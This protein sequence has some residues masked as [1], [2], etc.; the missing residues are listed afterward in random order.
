MRDYLKALRK[1][2]GWSQLEAAKAFNISATY[3]LYIETGE[4]QK[5]MDITTIE[6]IATVFN[7]SV[8]SIIELENAYRAD[9]KN[10]YEETNN[11][12][13]EKAVTEATAQE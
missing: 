1:E 8:T 11:E 4:R 7:K 9:P 3:Y 2:K 13:H 12:Q 10:H 5:D 6:K